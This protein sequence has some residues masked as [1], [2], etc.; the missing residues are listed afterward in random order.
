MMFDRKIY[1]DYVRE[2][3][4]GGSLTQGQVDGQNFILDQW[5]KNP[6][7][8]DLRHLA[9]CFATTKH[10]TASSML[11]IEEYGKGKGMKYGVEDPAGSGN[12]FYGRGFVQLT[13]ADNYKKATEKL[14][15]GGEDDLYKY[16][17]RAL[18]GMI[19]AEIMFQGMWEGWFRSG[20]SLPKYFSATVNDP[21]TARE[22]INGDKNY[23]VSWDSRTIGN[24]IK[25]YHVDF[26]TA[27][28]AAAEPPELVA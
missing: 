13:W 7:S 28:E 27:L 10:E 26:L 19:A 9:Y 2:R 25:G 5:E 23:T 1:F 12:V 21:F 8:P 17:D 22:I 16:P 20:H 11:P 4:F 15:L 3:P 14:F 6:L 18:D 24:I